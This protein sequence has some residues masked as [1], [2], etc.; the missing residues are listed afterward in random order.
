MKF[1]KN[2]ISLKR[3][4]ADDIELLRQWRN[5]SEV[6]RFMEYR[7]TISP[8]M[9]KEW[10]KSVD[11]LDNFY[12]III[13]EG[14]KIGLLYEKKISS[15]D[16]IKTESGMFIAD[17]A[18]YDTFIPLFASIIMIEL[19]MF[20]MGGKE[21]YIRILDDNQRSIE[22]NKNLGYVLCE[23]QEGIYNQLY[24]LTRENFIK[25]TRKLRQAIVKIMGGDNKTYLVIEKEDYVSGLGQFVE[26]NVK[27]S[28]FPVGHHFDEEGNNVYS[29]DLNVIEELRS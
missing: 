16:D 20:T 22:Y 27:N 25:K 4:T 11:N 6:A 10:F 5:S 18:Y 15:E 29:L 7:E 14:Q 23:G 12:Y 17:T 8:E 26:N 21:S 24:V 13:Y 1:I 28:G 19:N 3:L 9:Q 2:G